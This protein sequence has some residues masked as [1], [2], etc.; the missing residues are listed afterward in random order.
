[1][2]ELMCAAGVMLLTLLAL[3]FFSTAAAH[4]SAVF[5]DSA[6]VVALQGTLQRVQ[7]SNPHS[8]LW[9]VV[10][11]GNDQQDVWALASYSA[12]MLAKRYGPGVWTEITAG[13][14]VTV[15]IHP[16]RDGRRSG[17]VISIVLAN[18]KVLN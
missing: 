11:K 8:W 6:K 18:G 5:Y 17:S 7:I 4:H 1:M 15:K 13:Q 10:D 16:L 2:R 12:T 3:A 14:K 9:L